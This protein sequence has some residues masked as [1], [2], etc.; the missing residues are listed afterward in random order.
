[1]TF[2]NTTGHNYEELYD[3]RRSDSYRIRNFDPDSYRIQNQLHTP[4]AKQRTSAFTNKQ[5]ALQ[6]LCLYRGPE[7]IRTAVGAFAELCLATRPQDL[8][9]N[10]GC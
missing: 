7:R 8:V 3:L 1:M 6:A 10:V 4:V 5:S 2:A 9:R